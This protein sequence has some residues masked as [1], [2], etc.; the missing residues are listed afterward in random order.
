MQ[1]PVERE[2][3]SRNILTL[4]DKEAAKSYVGLILQAIRK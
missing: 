4:I 3:L 1:N 2:T